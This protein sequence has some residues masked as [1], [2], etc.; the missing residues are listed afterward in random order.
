MSVSSR[1]SPLCH[2]SKLEWAPHDTWS[3]IQPPVLLLSKLSTPLGFNFLLCRVGQQKQTHR[4]LDLPWKGRSVWHTVNVQSLA[5]WMTQQ[6][7]NARPAHPAQLWGSSE[8]TGHLSTKVR[9]WAGCEYCCSCS[10]YQGEKKKPDWEK[11]ELRAHVSEGLREGGEHS[12]TSVSQEDLGGMAETG[13]L[14]MARHLPSEFQRHNFGKSPK[15]HP[16]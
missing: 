12:G 9:V 5:G 16:L 11:D 3:Q 13:P 6:A 10:I 4:L 8:D 14:F 1:R 2:S 7:E 15:C